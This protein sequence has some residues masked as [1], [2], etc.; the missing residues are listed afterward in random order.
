MPDYTYAPAGAVAPSVLAHLTLHIDA[1]RKRGESGLG[2]VPDERAIARM[3]DAAFWASLRREEGMEPKISLAFLTREEAGYPL[4]LE[5]PIPLNPAALTRLSAVVERRGVHLGVSYQGGGEL[6]VWGMVRTIPKYCCVVEVTEPG[7][8]V[9]KHHRGEAQAKFVNVAVLQGD[10]VKVIDEHASSLPDCPSLLT[11]LLAFDSP[12]MWA[13][14]VSVLVQV[15][16]SMRAHGRGGVL[17]VVPEGTD[18]WR[19][20]IVYPMTYEVSPPFSEL[21]ML[22][23]GPAD[24]VSQRAWREELNRAVDAVA[25]LT[26]IDGATVMTNGYHVL[27]FGAKVA[28]RK[29]GTQIEQLTLTEPIEGTSALVL[30]PG[31]IGATRHLAGAQ[32][33]HDQRDAMAL[34]ASQDGR[35]TVFAWSP[36]EGMVH[37]HRIETLLL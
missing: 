23:S 14:T 32:F 30:S 7:L 13:G 2:S 36:R 10:S 19:S 25:S 12:S 31:E 29:G 37:A 20:S 33:V 24:G 11:S 5:R 27:A 35:F 28:R 15:A 21:A 18:E 3:I 34:V 9:I 26:A 1:A 22:A 16:V 8:L 6:S 17:L 4:I